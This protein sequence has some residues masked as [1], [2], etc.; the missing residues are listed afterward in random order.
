MIKIGFIGLISHKW[1]GGYNY[2]QNLT[3]ALSQIEKKDFII[4]VFL[5]KKTDSKIKE[6]F[7]KHAIVIEDSIFDRYSLKWFLYKLIQK[8][9][10]AN[11]ILESFLTKYGIEVL[12]HSFLSNFKTIKTINW[13]PDF[14]H[15]HL[16]EMFSKKQIKDRNKSYREVIR[17]SDTIIL[18]SKS[19]LSDF[20]AFS[21][22]Y[23]NKARVLHFVSQP[24]EKYRKY[25]ESDKKI[26]FN[27]FKLD[28]KYFY[29]PN[30][31]WKHK[32]HIIVFKALQVLKNS[33]LNVNIVC[34]GYLNDFRDKNHIHNI[35][36]FIKRNNLSSNIKI[37]GVVD[38][39]DVFK[40]M[41]FS[42]AVINPSLFEGWSSTVEECKS[43]GKNMILSDISVHKEQYP[44]ATFFRKMIWKS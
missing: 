22:N 2:F 30:D 20:K 24:S 16:P 11:Y 13:I 33:G 26:L 37:L 14:Q 19:S 32:N 9:F 18:S 12:S 17:N 43:V 10:S 23:H 44:S 40:L 41:K 34:T 42:I 4:Y 31:F 1:M 36:D 5:G 28:N 3:F 27:K 38:Y 8:L 29:M 15:M 21:P 7:K 39:E 35:N 6:M 25:G